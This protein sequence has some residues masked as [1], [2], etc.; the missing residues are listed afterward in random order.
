ML[1]VEQLVGHRGWPA[2]YPENT[3]PGFMAACKE[4]AL[5]LECDIQLSADGIPM[6]IHDEE[7]ARVAGKPVRVRDLNSDELKTIPVTHDHHSAL[8]PGEYIPPSLKELFQA[9]EAYP[10]VRLFVEIKRHSLAHFGL[11]K[12]CDIILRECKHFPNRAMIISFR[13]DAIEY[14]QQNSNYPVGW[15]LREWSDDSRQMAEHLK[16]EFLFVEHA[17]V[18]VSQ[19]VLW[20]GAWRWVLYDIIDPALANAWVK[21]GASMVVTW[22]IKVLLES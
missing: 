10:H 4:G 22:D 5:F 17:M 2:R 18:N 7:L 8:E 12:T 15:I 9:L 13:A 16:P 19:Q 21:R 3:L 20:P 14:V 11:R 6:V 1:K